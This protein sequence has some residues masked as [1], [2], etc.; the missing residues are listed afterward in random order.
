ML[1]RV[2]VTFKRIG[3]ITFSTPGKQLEKKIFKYFDRGIAFGAAHYAFT[4]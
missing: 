4:F 1:D 3:K 2:I